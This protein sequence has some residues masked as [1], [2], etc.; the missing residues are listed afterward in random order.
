MRKSV[1][2]WSPLVVITSYYAACIGGFLATMHAFPRIGRY[3]PTGGVQDLMSDQSNQLQLL[4]APAVS[5]GADVYTVQLALSVVGA[6]LLMAPV[7]WTYF[8]TTPSKR[9]DRSFAQTMIILPVIVAG[10]VMIVQN[11]IALAFSLAGIVAA[12]RFRFTLSEAAHTLYIFCATAIGLSAGVSAIGIATVIS[13]GFV[14]GTLLLW[15]LDYGARLNSPF[16]AFLTS[17]DREEDEL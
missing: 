2:V 4:N 6:A 13:V 1:R 9:V 15:W 3:L 11:S 8:I 16:F 5:G 12:V 7:S 14:Y 17:R 10:I